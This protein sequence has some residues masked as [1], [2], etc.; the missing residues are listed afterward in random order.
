MAS[1][2]N[3][4][5]D[6]QGTAEERLAPGGFIQVGNELWKAE[7][8]SNS[9]VIEKGQTVRIRGIRGLTLLVEQT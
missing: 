3:A 7:V 1:Q 8:I 6:R 5:L 9:R 4:I 2:S